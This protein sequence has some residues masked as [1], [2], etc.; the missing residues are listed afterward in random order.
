MIIKIK[1]N[2][3]NIHEINDV[4]EYLAMG[5][6]LIVKFEDGSEKGFNSKGIASFT[7]ESEDE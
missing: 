6:F 1:T 3:K 2:K 5:N 4:E 7:V